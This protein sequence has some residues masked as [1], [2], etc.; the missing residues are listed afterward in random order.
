MSQEVIAE[1]RADTIAT[2]EH[3]ALSR[4]SFL[5][6]MAVSSALVGIPG[7]LA[8]CGSTA[9]NSTAKQS[10]HV[11]VGEAFWKDWNPWGHFSQVQFGVQRNVFDRLIELR[12]D[13]SL[14]PGLATS[15]KQLD[16]RTWEF[17]LRKGVTFHDQTPFTAA[18][19]KASIERASGKVGKGL[20]IT[21]IWGIPHEVRIVDDH[22]VRLRGDKPFGPLL[23]T[24]TLSDIVSHRDAVGDLSRLAERPNGTGP[25]KLSRDE[26][27]RKS[28]TAFKP[29]YERL[30]LNDLTMEY[31]D[32]AGTRVNA[33][34]SGQ[35]GMIQRLRPD[36]VGIVG[37]RSGYQTAATTSLEVQHLWIVGNKPPFDNV[38]V[39]RA[40]AW[41]I[42]REG[43]AKVVGGQTKVATSHIGGEVLYHVPQT[44]AYTFDPAQAKAELAKAG[45]T[46]PVRFELVASTGKYPNSKAAAELMATNLNK[47]GFD[48]EL[49][50]LE[51]AAFNS[52]TASK[53]PGNAFFSGWG[54]I[55]RDPDFAVA[56]PFHSPGLVVPFSDKRVDALIDEGRTI[57]DEHRRATIYG[58]LQHELWNQLPTLPI[59]YS[60]VTTGLT[61]SLE[62]Y[63]PSP[64]FIDSFQPL[65]FVNN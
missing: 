35:A 22:T 59:I 28:F 8:A 33:L 10:L 58:Q 14:R 55:M 20:T 27:S 34:L 44:P 41:G 47:A 40:L 49:T 48:V 24:L 11:L 45:V 43:V 15:W 21:A 52:K 12:P 50:V 6:R 5:Q 16:E 25:F 13:L 31:I 19:V 61:K 51:F 54:N 30:E 42:D 36:Q 64:S 32:D 63:H 57:I 39:R 4:R 26:R 18:D 2:A 38:H 56:L 37:D 9:S 23:Q 29:H 46:T 60:D 3:V 53:D 1:R 7:V 62:G 65:R 17:A